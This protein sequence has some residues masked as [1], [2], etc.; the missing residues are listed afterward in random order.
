[1][2]LEAY[3]IL[4]FSFFVVYLQIF[5][6][7]QIKGG[8]LQSRWPLQNNLSSCILR[9]IEL[10]G[11]LSKAFN[12]V[13]S[14]FLLKLSPC[15]CVVHVQWGTPGPQTA[16]SPLSSHYVEYKFEQNSESE[17]SS[18]PM[19]QKKGMMLFEVSSYHTTIVQSKPQHMSLF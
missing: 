10:D 4:G 2:S 1:M 16:L 8:C 13:L 15:L 11:D 5:S 19:A 17:E 9:S 7:V 14:Y 18:H 12:M 3:W 6:R